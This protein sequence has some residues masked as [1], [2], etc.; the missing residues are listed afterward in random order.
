[1][2]LLARFT[3]YTQPTVTGDVIVGLSYELN[4]ESLMPYHFDLL[5]FDTIKSADLREHITRVGKK[6]YG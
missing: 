6:I 1:M 3:H 4:E 2:F 5:N